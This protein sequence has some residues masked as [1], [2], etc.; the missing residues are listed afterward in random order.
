[1]NFT[2][3]CHHCGKRG[4]QQNTSV[5]PFVFA[6]WYTEQ[7]GLQHGCLYCRSCG[8]VHDTV[9]TLL[10]GIKLL[11]GRFPSK[12]VSSFTSDVFQQ[13]VYNGDVDIIPR[14]V[15][16]AMIEDKRISSDWYVG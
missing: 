10:G 7:N 5:K 12:V 14:V 13:R 4:S 15:A 16:Q 3:K 2:F 11:F 9:G 8:A 6:Y 1:M